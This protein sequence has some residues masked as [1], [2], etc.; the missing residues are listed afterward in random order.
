VPVLRARHEHQERTRLHNDAAEF[1]CVWCGQR[2]V[3]KEGDDNAYAFFPADV[4]RA[5]QTDVKP[6]F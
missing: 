3:R 2:H 6:L 4:A 5:F 1:Q